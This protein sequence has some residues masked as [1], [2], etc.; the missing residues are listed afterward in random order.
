M[1]GFWQKALLESLYAT[2]RICLSL[3]RVAGNLQSKVLR[4]AMLMLA[5]S[6]QQS[7]QMLEHAKSFVANPCFAQN[8]SSHFAQKLMG[9]A[10]SFTRNS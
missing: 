5:Q 8:A 2:D 6:L 10:K 4:Q 3:Q 7:N 9:F 1:L